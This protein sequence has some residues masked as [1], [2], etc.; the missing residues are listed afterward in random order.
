MLIK[1]RE[2]KGF[3][4]VE[5]MIVVAIIG[6]LAAVAV[7]FYQRYVAK[8]KLTTK[9]FPG[10]HAIETNIGAIY[11]VR[12]ELPGTGA[13]ILASLYRDAST[14]C[15]TPNWTGGQLEITLSNTVACGFN[16]LIAGM[17]GT[18]IVARP[19]TTGD[20]ITQWL[21]TGPV[22]EELGLN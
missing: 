17:T 1:M 18:H 10:Q 19:E 4:L 20:K 21:L 11:A 16:R 3:T 7:P 6:I 5:L 15:F 2:N 13:T 9:V 12:N 14:M 8:S 22:V